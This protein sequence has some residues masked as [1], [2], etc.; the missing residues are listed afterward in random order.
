LLQLY[1]LKKGF[2]GLGLE[3]EDLGLACSGE[4]GFVWVLKDDKW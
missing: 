1:G 2:F 3:F 4:L